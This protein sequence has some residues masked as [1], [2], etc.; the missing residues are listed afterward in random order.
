MNINDFEIVFQNINNPKY[1]E[2]QNEF[3]EYLYSIKGKSMNTIN[4]Y[5]LDIMLMFK[6]LKL[7]KGI[8]L[9]SI[10]FENID[11][12]DIDDNFIKTIRLEDLY[13]YLNFSKIYRNNTN[14][15]RSRKIACI[16]S[17]F[18]YLEKKARIIV[19]NPADELEMPKIEKRTP[20]YLNFEESKRL[21]DSI[22]GRN[23]ERDT[24]IITIFLNCGVRLSELCGMNISDIKSDTISVIGKGGKQ[25]TIY[26]NKSCLKSIEEYLRV[27][28]DMNGNYKDALFLSEQNHRIN[29]RTVQHIVTKYVKKASLP[30]KYTP[31]KLRHTAATLLYKNGADIRSIQEI[32]GHDSIATTQIY[33]HVDSEMLRAAVRVNPLNDIQD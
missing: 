14:S 30:K 10:E 22:S 18:N 21:L 31:H 24:C 17:F 29:K 16:K 5:S 4:S 6:F 26:L 9:N 23:R 27:R 8:V 12:N 20:I 11:I 28:S 19:D 32:L 13:A 1:P 15:T 3:R 33:T 7:Y 2:R 25:R